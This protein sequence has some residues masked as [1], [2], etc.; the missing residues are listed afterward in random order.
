MNFKIRVI[1]LKQ[2]EKEKEKQVQKQPPPKPFIVKINQFGKLIIGFTRSIMLPTFARYPEFTSQQFF[3]GNCT[4][5]GFCEQSRLLQQ[6]SETVYDGS[7]Q[8]SYTEQDAIEA[9]DILNRGQIY[10]N[11][12]KVPIIDI[13]V[14]PGAESDASL[15]GFTWNCT[16]VTDT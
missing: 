16:K 3:S 15:L 12:I 5:G 8:T 9:R 6:A 13:S 4:N 10:V 11:S 1:L 7:L 14:I 2:A